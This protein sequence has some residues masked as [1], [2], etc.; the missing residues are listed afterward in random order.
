MEKKWK[1]KIEG[2]VFLQKIVGP[3]RNFVEKVIPAIPL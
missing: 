3:M 1:R 2:N